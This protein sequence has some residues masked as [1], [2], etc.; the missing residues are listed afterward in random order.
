MKKSNIKTLTSKQ[1]KI[2]Y[3]LILSIISL[4][5]IWGGY[6]SYQTEN[7][8]S[9][10][11]FNMPTKDFAPSFTAHR[12]DYDQV[13]IN[14]YQYTIN[15]ADLDA[16]NDDNYKIIVNKMTD[17]A[18]RIY[19]ND[20]LVCSEGDFLNGQSMF[21]NSYVYGTFNSSSLKD[22][23][24]LTIET[25]A[26]YKS[27]IESDSVVI[28]SDSKS[29][30]L[31]SS[32]DLH[33]LRLTIFGIGFLFFAAF[34]TIYI[35]MVSNEKDHSLIYSSI[36]TFLLCIYFADYIKVI[37][38][39][40]S[41]FF[42]KRLFLFGLAG[43]IM[44]YMLSVKSI[45]KKRLPYV[46]VSILV[47]SYIVILFYAKDL[48]QFKTLYEYWYFGLVANILFVIPYFLKTSKTNTR[49]F[50]FLISFILLG[51]YTLFV[52]LLEFQGG[53]FALNS[54]LLYIVILATLPLLIGFDAISAKETAL[55][56][57]QKEKEE[58][59]ITSLED[60]LTGVWNK[61]Y[62]NFRL[63]EVTNKTTIAM[64]D[65]DDFKIVN[66][67]YGHPAGDYVI[68]E[69]TKTF[70]KNVRKS[71]EVFRFGGD[72]FVLIFD[73]CDLSEAEE[74]LTIIC[75]EIAER[76]FNYL[77]NRFKVSVSIGLCCNEK[78]LE[79]DQLLKVV[80]HS[81]YMAKEHGKNQV[82]TKRNL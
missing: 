70:L 34:F 3:T 24:I 75:N 12:I 61:R 9:D 25:Y 28:I 18:I 74:R 6:T 2:V 50:I 29:M 40:Q 51:V 23:N 81:L 30:D 72:E 5:A 32:L 65:I 33:G 20:N 64:Y 26:L 49:S 8:S 76:T 35:F 57:E 13:G 14:R 62:L 16:I 37:S 53:Y 31:I 77:G 52:V 79:G 46:F 42:Y 22:E 36:A 21:K 82:Y 7:I 19:I 60:S 1:L 44:F 67:Q 45:V 17:N 58:I 48:I 41:Y 73:E 55:I 47:A 71:D 10:V 38:L 68:Q 54:P 69:I 56:N 39:S 27:G 63:N 4:I 78:G 11:G 43:G 80:D 15:K 59:L 66:D